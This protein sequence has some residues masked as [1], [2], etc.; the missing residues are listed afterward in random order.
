M[1]SHMKPSTTLMSFSQTDEETE[2]R[3]EQALGTRLNI[4]LI[5]INQL[6]ASTFCVRTVQR[7][8]RLLRKHE[9]LVTVTLV[10]RCHMTTSQSYC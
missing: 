5:I 8:S 2:P 4:I 6:N 9:I 10:S 3:T 7:P 1:K